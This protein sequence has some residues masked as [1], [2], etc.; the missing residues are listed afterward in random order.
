MNFSTPDVE[1]SDKFC[2]RQFRKFNPGVNGVCKVAYQ[3]MKKSY[4]DK[5]IL[6]FFW[7]LAQNDLLSKYMVIGSSF[8]YFWWMFLV[9]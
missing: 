2:P 9:E 5:N 4:D 7:N 3:R 1:I 6:I 8:Y